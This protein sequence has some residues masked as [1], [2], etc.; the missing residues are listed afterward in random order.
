MPT[1]KRSATGEETLDQGK[2]V[3]LIVICIAA[4]AVI[5]IPL[6]VIGY[7]YLPPDD[8]LRHAAKAISGKAWD[9]VI[10]LRDEVKM[11]SHQSWHFLLGLVHKITGMD[12]D[13]LVSF[14]IVLFFI[15]F[16]LVPIFFLERPEAWLA[17]LLVITI[18]NLG[19]VRRLFLGRPYIVTMTFVL[20]LF[21]NWQRLKDKRV[22]YG[23]MALLTIF[24][25]LSTWVHGCWYMLALPVACFFLA[26][27]WQAGIRVAVC[28]VCGIILGA[29]FTG[30]PYLYL[31]HNVMS[32]FFVL[33][34]KIP[35]R[36]LAMELQSFSGD[37]L[38][39]I[40]VFALMAW[41]AIRG[42]WD[43]K[44]I[45]NPIFILL[46]SGWVLGFF[47]Q[48]FWLDW[49]LAAFLVWMAQEFQ[50]VF[51]K[52]IKEFSS[53]R[54]VTAAIL[55]FV[56]FAAVTCDTDSR[57]TSNLTIEY[58]SADDPGQA[59]WLPDSGGIIY[60]SNMSIFYQTFFKNPHAPWRYILGWEQTFMPKD[61]YEIYSK[62][63]WNY[64]ADQAYEPWVRKMRPEDRL[65][66][67]RESG[68]APGI[69]GL[70]WHYVATDTW[71]GR[72]ARKTDK[73]IAK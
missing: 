2:I 5:L 19:F 31:K 65:I 4:L 11:D 45:D 38:T 20:V 54:I 55:A 6:K 23:T 8:A 56:L 1:L 14:S 67:R 58:L 51:E 46:V 73:G 22:S 66:I 42:A 49:G 48:R 12:Q 24:A 21:L 27:E 36:L 15:I 59:P 57:W 26:R 47:V 32:M 35:Q 18:F 34:D 7:G 52:Y 50:D 53:K 37:A 72:I 41:R 69:S 70:E 28:V 62:I 16:A 68:S 60:S 9:Q 17:S 40:V 43:I 30:H 10:V 44:R 63:F 71:S 33:G 3:S 64:G 13:G 61:D 25:A 29:I 39:V